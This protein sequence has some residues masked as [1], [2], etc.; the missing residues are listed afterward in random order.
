M[1]LISDTML[2]EEAA[3]PAPAYPP[4]F[5]IPE[6]PSLANIY[7]F[8][9]GQPF[10]YYA[11]LRA[12]APVAWMDM[13]VSNGEA[14][15]GYWALT[16]YE[17]IKQAGLQPALYSSQRG[18]IYMSTGAK[19]Q[20]DNRISR[21]AVNN[22]ICMDREFHIPMRMQQRPFFTSN[23]V[24][25]LRDT[26]AKK[27]DAF[28]DNMARKG[29]VVDFVPMFS[30][31]LPLFT[32]CE[33]LGVNEKDRSKIIKW[34]HYLELAQN[35]FATKRHGQANPFFVMKFL[36]NT[37]KMFQY[38]ERVLADRRENPRDDL[39]TT[40]AQAEIGGE[41]LNQAYLDGSWLL[42]IFAGNDTARNSISGTMKL[43]TEFP[44]Q[45]NTL[46]EDS[47]RIKKMVPEALR[48]ISPVISMRRTLM[49]DTELRGQKMM[50]DEKVVF[51]YGAANRDPEVFENPDIFDIDRHNSEDHIAFGHGPHNCLGKHA[52][53]MQLEVAYERLL[54]RFPD[55]QWTGKIAHAPNN[56]VS[57]VTSLEVN[58]G[59]ERN[60]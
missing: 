35:Y 21:A 54:A 42:I 47:T 44:E 6:G 45:K 48:L 41:K 43:L 26:V 55:A 20:R 53:L 11:K 39:L 4:V 30:E 34:M 31:Q 27:T 3:L 17:D 23:F 5:D 18:S 15:K 28:L 50:Q 16:R 8:T 60:A 56:L 10:D 36:Y 19:T 37:R 58:L 13:P 51:F 24:Q 7:N 49:Q 40:I 29:P 2:K 38:G 52:A 12:H 25:T 1:K 32:L 22:L 59:R 14:L 9:Q 46:I 33:M 57:A